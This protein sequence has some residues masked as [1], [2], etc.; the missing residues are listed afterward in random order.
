MT[1][2]GPLRQA[3][4]A[5]QEEAETVQGF[6]MTRPQLA[7]VVMILAVIGGVL[8]ATTQWG[9]GAGVLTGSI[10]IA[11]YGILLGIGS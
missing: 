8:G 6:V 4:T 2:M 9:W 1:T 10:M 7:I 3:N 11:V 5:Q